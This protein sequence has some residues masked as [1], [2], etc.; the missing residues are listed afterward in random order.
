MIS[1]VI[2]LR[3]GL[4]IPLAGEAE[5]ILNTP[6][7]SGVYA[8]NPPDFH[9]LT[10]KLL[11]KEGDKLKAGSPI[12]YDKYNEEIMFTSPVSGVFSKLVRGEKRR[13]LEIHITPDDTDEYIDFGA[14]DPLRMSR[15]EI[16]NKLVKSGLWPMIIQRPY[17]VIANPQ[18]KPRDIFVS[19]F[20]TVPLA[21]D[22]DFV[23]NGQ[24]D[25]FQTG[26]NV[27]TKLTDGNVNL[28]VH[29]Q[30]N[31]SKAFLEA[32]NVEIYCF[33]GKHPAGNVGIQIHHINPIN[34]GD[35]VWHA[36]IQAVIMMGRLFQTGTY[37]ARKVVVH[38]GTE[39]LNQRY[40]RVINGAG[41]KA[42]TANNINQGSKNELRFIS[43]DVLSGTEISPDG[44]VGFYDN[45]I[46][47]IPEGDKRDFIGWALPQLNKY[48][49]SRTFLSFLNPWKK[50]NINTN[51]NGGE[52]PFVITGQYEKVLPMDILP[53]HLI[54]SI[55][56]KDIDMMEKLGIYEVAPEDF[57]LCEFVCTSKTEVQTIVRQGL[58]L[59]R[60]EFE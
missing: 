51:L 13:I 35:I 36:D 53:V 45:M 44:F 37:D 5:K 59:I 48:S 17:S 54:K 18:D 9:G 4:N 15:E 40:Y 47:V 1:K 55:L 20:S 3:K 43:G 19:A 57:A 24:E 26:L 39:A 32:K 21:P 23:V 50:Y 31:T 8:L 11:I 22:N 10:P 34:K 7:R 6:S 2:K 52:R 25:A 28:S 58:D 41:I 60:K 29:C 49:A 30:L 42:F 27:L 56:I 33:K 46:T 16:V 38:V 14:G 12:F